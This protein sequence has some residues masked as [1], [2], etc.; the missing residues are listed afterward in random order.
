MVKLR[1]RVGGDPGGEP[2]T[3]EIFLV[4]P[5]EALV[6][7][8]KN[9]SQNKAYHANEPFEKVIAQLFVPVKEQEEVDTERYVVIQQTFSKEEIGSVT[10]NSFSWENVSSIAEEIDRIYFPVDEI[11]ED[12]LT[13]EGKVRTLTPASYIK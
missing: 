9:Y 6:E 12:D 3:E 7:V 11:D 2:E 5:E 1:L 10:A 13:E 8:P 4:S